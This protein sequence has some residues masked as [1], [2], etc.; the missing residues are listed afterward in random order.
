MS[1]RKAIQW[2]RGKGFAGKADK[3]KESFKVMP[4]ETEKAFMGRCMEHMTSKGKS[5]DQALG[6][7]LGM[8]N[9]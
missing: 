5:Y 9:Q 7:C 1:I 8:W 3:K 4:G 6:A 2:L